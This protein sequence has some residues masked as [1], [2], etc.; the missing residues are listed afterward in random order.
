MAA[1][2]RHILSCLLMNSTVEDRRKIHS[3][4]WYSMVGGDLT[5]FHG[6]AYGGP[7]WTVDYNDLELGIP[8]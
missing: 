4:K 2:L 1:Y 5:P 6:E 7:K 8:C 3:Q